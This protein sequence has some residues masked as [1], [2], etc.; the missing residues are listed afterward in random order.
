MDQ[1]EKFDFSWPKIWQSDIY[2]RNVLTS[3]QTEW[4]D[5][6]TL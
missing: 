3:N 6:I 1:I 4:R 2:F 5:V